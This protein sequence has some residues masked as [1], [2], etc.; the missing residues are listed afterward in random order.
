MKIAI[1]TPYYADVTAEYAE[2][3]ARMMLY[4]GRA[5][6]VYNGEPVVPEIEL[7]L[8]RSTVLQRCRNTLAKAAADWGANYL[9]W[10]DADHWF[11]PDALLRLLSHN[12]PVVGVNCPR[13]MEPTGPTAVSLDGNL[14]WT[15]EELAREEKL[16][17]VAHPGLG[18]CLVDMNVIKTL[19]APGPDGKP[20]P[21]FAMEML[22]EGLQVIA[23]DVFFFRRVNAAGFSVWVDHAL[24]WQI[25]H[26][27]TK[28]LTNAD[29]EAQRAAFEARTR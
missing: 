12:R 23:E 8:Y 5:T 4:T 25:G 3:L 2:C 7:F 16:E 17:Q 9:L 22:G 18:L 11:P 26:V 27:Y 19:R 24:S 20:I 6:F 15:T 13:R 14:I 10:I 28:L 29:A 1:C 21:L